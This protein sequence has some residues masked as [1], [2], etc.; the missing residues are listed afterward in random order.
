VAR[1]GPSAVSL[2]GVLPEGYHLQ[3]LRRGDASALAEAY[4][5]NRAHLA[6]WEPV[7]DESFYTEQGQ[8]R[9]IAVQLDATRAGRMVPWLIMAG[10]LVAGRLN[11]N[12]I[13]LG[14]MRSASL[15]YWVDADHLG[16]G[17]ASGAVA[18]GCADADARGLHRLEAGTLL[19]N[20]AS[21]RALER[22][23][24][25]PFG[26][27]PGYLFIAGAWQDHRLYQRLLNDRPA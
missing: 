12:H 7:R 6:P 14:V 22:N 16:R 5:R 9:S 26:V 11:L 27:A 19:N 23:G 10:D 21:Q 13:V 8:A 3:L 20:T 4:V 25:V 24:F 1:G 2:D 18:E 15:G 17:V